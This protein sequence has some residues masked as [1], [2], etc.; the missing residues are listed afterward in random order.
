MKPLP[1]QD[2]TLTAEIIPASSGHALYCSSV[3][4]PPARMVL[5]QAYDSAFSIAN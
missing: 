3:V 2:V 1:L 4:S 5:S